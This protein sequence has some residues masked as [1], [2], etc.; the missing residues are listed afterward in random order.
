MW[1]NSLSRYLR[2][3]EEQLSERNSSV[4][5]Q[6]AS[7]QDALVGSPYVGE[8]DIDLSTP[9]PPQFLLEDQQAVRWRETTNGIIQ[10]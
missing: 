4:R 1:L 8:S 7:A 3:L 9:H 5:H 10:F 6:D 2:H